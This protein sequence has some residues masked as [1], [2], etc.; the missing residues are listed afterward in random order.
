MAASARKEKKS[1]DV[2][3]DE[4]SF[5]KIRKADSSSN[6]SGRW[7]WREIARRC[8][9]WHVVIMVCVSSCF[10]RKSGSRER[11]SAEVAKFWAG[12]WSLHDVVV[13]L[14]SRSRCLD[15]Q[16]IISNNTGNLRATEMNHI[17]CGP[18]AWGE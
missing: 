13:V 3:G 5:W 16:I 12:S 8:R 1:D 9:R 7:P 10:H 15:R 17:I 2:K 14:A 18:E 6:S 4:S 11:F